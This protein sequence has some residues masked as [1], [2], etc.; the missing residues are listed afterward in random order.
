MKTL[1]TLVLCVSISQ[2]QFTKQ[3]QDDALAAI[4][5]RQL[6]AMA[7]LDSMQASLNMLDSISYYSRHGYYDLI[8][9]RDSVWNR[10]HW[11]R[12]KADSVLAQTF[13]PRIKKWKKQ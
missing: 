4:A 2:A 8:P 5:N 13:E 6:T 7:Y 9:M 12:Q 1:I 11:Y 3:Q 10:V